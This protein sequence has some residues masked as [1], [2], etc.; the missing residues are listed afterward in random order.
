M[1]L[2]IKHIKG[3]APLTFCLKKGDDEGSAVILTDPMSLPV[4]GG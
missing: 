4:E 3:A 2:T 1:Y